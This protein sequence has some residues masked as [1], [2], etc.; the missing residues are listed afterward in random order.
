MLETKSEF[1]GSLSR[2]TQKDSVPPSLLEFVSVLEHGGDI[3]TQLDHG[4]SQTD[5]SLAQLLQFNCHKAHKG[6]TSCMHSKSREPRFAVYNGLLLFAKTRKRQLIDIM[7]Q[8]G[9]S[10]SY[11]RVLRISKQLGESLVARAEVEGVVCPTKLRHGVFTTCAVDHN[12]SST[13]A[14]TS[15]HRTGISFFQHP[16]SVSTGEERNVSIAVTAETTSKSK[17]VPSLSEYY[18]NVPPAH[19]KKGNPFLHVHL[20]FGCKEIT[21]SKQLALEYEWFEKV[22]ISLDHENETSLSWAAHHASKGHQSHFEI[23]LST[24]MPLFPESA[25]SV[26]MVKH[27][28]DIAK[29][30]TNFLNPSQVPVVTVDQVLFALAKQIQWHWPTHY[31]EIKMFIKFGGLHVEIAAFEDARRSF[32]RQWLDWCFDRGRNCNSW[33]S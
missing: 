5:L 3:K 21:L 24:L 12:P 31:G 7:Y 27:A 16:D 15:F 30:T 26:A 13:T 29:K 20:A 23:S 8:N 32:E 17:K 10:I 18:T 14:H 4:T 25:Y 11:D 1:S 2:E 9:L 19:F 22:S 6:S 28:M 33:N